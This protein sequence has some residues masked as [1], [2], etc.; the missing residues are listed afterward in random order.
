MGVRVRDAFLINLINSAAIIA[1]H[2]IGRTINLDFIVLIIF[3]ILINLLGTT[4]SLNME[5]ELRKNYLLSIMTL[6]KRVQQQKEKNKIDMILNSVL[7]SEIA[8]RL[9]INDY[10]FESRGDIDIKGKGKMK[11]YF[12]RGKVQRASSLLP[13][14]FIQINLKVKLFLGATS[15]SKL[16]G[17][18]KRVGSTIINES[19]PTTPR[20][21]TISSPFQDKE[22]PVDT[23]D[24]EDL[25]LTYEV[26]KTNLKKWVLTFLDLRFPQKLNNNMEKKFRESLLFP[27]QS[28]KA[29]VYK[30]VIVGVL[31]A[32]AIL[33]IGLNGWSEI[34]LASFVS[35]HV[36]KN[37]IF[38]I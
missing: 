15:Y 33:I 11:T 23:H 19:K 21:G 20:H 12:L 2:V 37:L 30:S 3:L 6:R 29:S 4:L 17:T 36:R 10:L 25:L 13:G 31:I 18:I 5:I 28:K 9:K 26:N 34:I 14:T 8:N 24:L 32:I 7:P 1:H 27:E 38:N 22:E 35:F 16:A